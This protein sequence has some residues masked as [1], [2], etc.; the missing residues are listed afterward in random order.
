MTFDAVKNKELILTSPLT[1]RVLPLEQVPDPVFSG[2]MVGEGA[3]VEAQANGLATLVAPC[4]G[5]VTLVHSAGHGVGIATPEGLELLLHVGLDTVEMEGRG[6]EPVVTVDQR[7]QPGQP[8]VRFDSGLIAREGHSLVSP[9]VVTNPE[10]LDSLE[11][12]ASGKVEAGRT[13]LLRLQVK[14]A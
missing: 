8:L 7:V 5:T 2:K 6:F 14:P 12:V 9:V 10:R 1:G 4:A 11:L 13:P 3:A